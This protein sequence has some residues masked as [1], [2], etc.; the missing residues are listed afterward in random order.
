MKITGIRLFPVPPR[1][2]FLAID[3]DAGVT[4]WGEPVL[5]GRARTVATAVEELSEHVVG[6]DPRNINDIWQVLYRGG[7]YR[8][9]PILMSAIAGIDQALWD[10]KGKE[11][12]RPVYELLGGRCRDKMLTYTWVGGDEPA[13]ECRQI[14]TLVAQGWSTFKLNGT[15]RLKRI[16]SSRAVDQVL[17]RISLIRERFGNS[18]D[19][20]LDFHGRVS[21]AMAKVLLKELEAVR[22]LFVEEPVLPEHCEHYA[23]LAAHTSIPLA[24]GE[25]MMSRF[26]FKRIF[27]QGGLA[28]VQPD[29]SHAGGITECT[30]IASMA[31][32]YDVGFAPHCPLGPIAL[33]ACL[34][35][36]FVAPNAVLQE[37][38]MGIHYNQGAELLDYVRNKDDFRIENGYIA[39][40]PRAGLGIDIDEQAVIAASKRAGDWRNPIWRHEDGSLAEW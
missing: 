11:I 28:I 36:D 23:R 24:A 25:R 9:G 12:G 20:G 6:K 17:E 33:A 38:S 32:A 34:A 27:E 16:D 19:F 37:Q 35:V 22:P 39:P 30:K 14:E 3:T 31:D 29:L 4:G 40:L 8:G 10:I 21:V 5:E 18:I 2:L 13:D 15:G 26:D 7:F 1:W